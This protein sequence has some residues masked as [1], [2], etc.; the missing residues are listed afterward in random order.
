MR[1]LGLCLILLLV[2]SW[3]DPASAAP[4]LS[5][6]QR[7]NL[8]DTATDH[9]AN[10]D[11][12]PAM[13]ELLDSAADWEADDFAGERGA[14]TPPVAD[15]AYLLANPAEVRGDL[16]LIEGRFIEQLRYPTDERD[17]RSHLA[18]VRWGDQL[19][20]WGIKVGEGD[21]DVVMV[22]FVD[23]DNTIVSPKRGEQVRVAARFYKVWEV[24]D[25]DG[26][27][28]QFLTFVGGAREVV[29]GNSAGPGSPGWGKVVLTLVVVAAGGFYGM[30]LFLV[31]KSKAQ[32]ARFE[33]MREA[34]HRDRGD[35]EEDDEEIDPDL[36]D[37]PAEALA[38]L[39]AKER[40]EV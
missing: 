22:Y 35:A 6:T 34:R 11:Q 25:R 5:D 32:R 17:G 3:A 29:A 30:R 19:T 14:A 1:R 8:D 15:Y 26:R 40:G 13:Y 28:F 23:P 37:D 27:P 7:Q 2:A 9:D 21:D 33:S 10:L 20:A 39:Q 36:P 4:A 24:P 31:K 38:Y 12:G 18:R 16:F